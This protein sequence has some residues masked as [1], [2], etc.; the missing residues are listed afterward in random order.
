MEK[1][2]LCIDWIPRP[3]SG[4]LPMFSRQFFMPINGWPLSATDWLLSFKLTFALCERRP[5]LIQY[6]NFIL[7]T[8]YDKCKTIS[9]MSKGQMRCIIHSP[10]LFLARLLPWNFVSSGGISILWWFD[11]DVEETFFLFDW[12]VTRWVCSETSA[13]EVSVSLLEEGEEY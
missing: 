13:V 11:L 5:F 7:Y 6:Q 2:V 8:K 12:Q 1:P 4:L 3:L 10:S 9:K